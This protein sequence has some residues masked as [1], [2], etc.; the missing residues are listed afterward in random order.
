MDIKIRDFEL[1]GAV[2][3]VLRFINS[4]DANKYF[5]IA[6]DGSK[7]KVDCLRLLDDLKSIAKYAAEGL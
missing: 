1:Y 7:I 4:C 3:A 2:N 6:P 5:L